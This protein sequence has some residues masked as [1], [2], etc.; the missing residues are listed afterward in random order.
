MDLQ[1]YKSDKDLIVKIRTDDS[2]LYFP[3]CLLI[4]NTEL[5]KMLDRRDGANELDLSDFSTLIV[6]QFLYYLEMNEIKCESIEELRNFCQLAN[7]LLCDFTKF[8]KSLH[9]YLGKLEYNLYYSIKYYKLYL[10]N[11]EINDTTL[12]DYRPLTDEIILDDIYYCS[13]MESTY[14]AGLEEISKDDWIY[15][16][17][18][19]NLPIEFL[20]KLNQVIYKYCKLS[21]DLGEYKNL[22]TRY[23]ILLDEITES[24][25]ENEYENECD[26]LVPKIKKVTEIITSIKIKINKLKAQYGPK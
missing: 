23:E 21:I 22:L 10:I 12:D 9:T 20:S 11:K 2:I 18:M 24:G 13:I 5:I 16:I 8:Y 3:K 17:D 15:I 25:D 6:T 26:E 14:T 4:N 1:R 7:Y 19:L